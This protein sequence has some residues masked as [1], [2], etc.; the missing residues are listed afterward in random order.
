MVV[1]GAG[2]LLI[3]RHRLPV[4]NLFL[5]CINCRSAIVFVLRNGARLHHAI[6]NLILIGVQALVF[7]AVMRWCVVGRRVRNWLCYVDD[8]C[9]R[10]PELVHTAESWCDCIDSILGKVYN[11]LEVHDLGAGF[12]ASLS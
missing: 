4:G 2:A 9:G 6:S 12:S 8:A 3:S 5:I 11:L 1:R 10:G 7:M